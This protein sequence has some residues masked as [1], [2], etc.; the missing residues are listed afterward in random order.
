MRIGALAIG[1]ALA[2]AGVEAARA[3]NVQFTITGGDRTATFELPLSPTPDPPV[4]PGFSFRISSVSAVVGG[5]AGT[6][7]D[8]DFF[9]N[10][11][12]TGGFVVEFVYRG[13]ASP[14][15]S[16]S[17][18]QFYT[19]AESSP[20]F[21]PG[22]YADLPN[23]FTGKIDTVKVSR[24]PDSDPTGPP[25]PPALSVPEPSTWAMLLLGFVGLSYAGYR[26]AKTRTAPAARRG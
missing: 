26:K 22:V 20:T 17:G 1:L 7:T 24:I 6:L 18:P 8:L 12:E 11:F 13:I 25:D 2:W 23:A 4:V 5:S 9:S 14:L 15:F 16:F 21:I 3:T 19:G 10:E